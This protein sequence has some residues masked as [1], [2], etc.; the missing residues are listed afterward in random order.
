MGRWKCKGERKVVEVVGRWKG[1]RWEKGW[2]SLNIKKI[3]VKNNYRKI[4]KIIIIMTW[5]LMWLNWNIDDEIDL[6]NQLDKQSKEEKKKNGGTSI[7]V[8]SQDSQP[9]KRHQI[10]NKGPIQRQYPPMTMSLS[11]LT[12]F[13]SSITRK[14]LTPTWDISY[15]T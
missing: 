15:Y 3:N 9:V 11:T 4:G 7:L 2:K 13:S 5:T 12:T 1:K 6:Q 14:R 10:C 8:L